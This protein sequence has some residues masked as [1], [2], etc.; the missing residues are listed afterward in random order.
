MALLAE[1]SSASVRRFFITSLR[2][3]HASPAV[4]LALAG[5]PVLLAAWALMSP[6]VIF[7]KVMTADLLFNLAGAWHIYVGQVPYVDFHDPSGQLSFI[8]TAIGFHLLGASPLAFLVNVA[9]VAA[10]LFATSFLAAVQRLPLLPAAIFVVFV[11]L[12]TLMPSNV[13]ERPDQYTFA[14]SYNRYC[15]SAY[16][17][18]A[19]ILFVPPR[20]RH[21]IVWIDVAVG[22]LLLAAMFYLKITYFAA[23]LATVAF[24]LLF[25][26]HVG[27]YWQAWIAVCAL[28]VAN[29]LA[30]H[31]HPYLSDILSWAES[32]AIRRGLLAMHLNNF[33]AALGE[34]VP[35]LALI[36]VA[37]WMWWT[38]RAPVRFPLTLVFLFVIALFLLSQ[39]S[40]VAGLPSNIVMLLVLYDQLRSHFVGVRSRDM[41]PLLLALLVFP[42]FAAGG[43]ALS[44]VGYHAKASDI[45]GLYVVDRTNLRGLAVP[46]GERGA[47][48]SS[49]DAFDYP[50][51]NTASPVPLYQV[52][53]YEYVLIL[54]EAAD[55]LSDREPG[56]IALF[57]DVN[58][59]PFMLGLQPPCGSNLWSTWSAPV[60]PADEYLAGIRYVLIPKFPLT[61][62]WTADL[63]RH[64]GSYLNEHFRRAVGTRSWILLARSPP[65]YL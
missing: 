41:A 34:Y 13:G 42:L 32:G 44:I 56:G 20:T 25:Q 29:S 51:R 50:G 28:L 46:N 58:P 6:P 31:N 59:L 45:R 22:G 55:L 3:A 33:A 27:R 65:G 43:F 7:S 52:S 4:L 15:W 14:M 38:G 54:Q 39:N 36:V 37:C 19:L 18:L 61:P 57:D 62:N 2:D 1:G 21:N 24:A 23:G 10:I 12:L 30:P 9:I 8:L 17:V 5:L 26:P 64:Y 60:R 49:S 48:R 35:Y 63:M 40:Q 16:S 47:F 53:H 11:C